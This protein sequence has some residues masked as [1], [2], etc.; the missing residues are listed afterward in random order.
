MEKYYINLNKYKKISLVCGSNTSKVYKVE[1]KNT[2]RI[3]IEIVYYF[4]ET[5]RIYKYFLS[6]LAFISNF[7]YPIIIEFLGIDQSN[8][9]QEKH[10]VFITEFISDITLNQLIQ[11][12]KTGKQQ[13]NWN[14][15]K[16]LI[17]IYGIASSISYLHRQNIIHQNLNLENIFET[18]QLYPKLLYLGLPRLN[19][20]SFKTKVFLAPEI[21]SGG[22]N[23]TSSDIYSFAMIVYSII[24]GEI[25]F[26]NELNQENLFEKIKNGHRPNINT[27]IPQSCQQ[28]IECCWSQDPSARPNIDTILNEL[29]NDDDFITAE[30]DT[31]EFELY[32]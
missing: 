7:S 24:T 29:K 27:K 28:L 25:P 19:D 5:S 31:T 20:Q 4:D 17:N 21:L 8:F 15:T 13:E 26:E 9:N 6:Q 22:E 3:F 14:F 1:E 10:L 30:I 16:K 2:D 12:E 18:S 11:N 32:I 23:T